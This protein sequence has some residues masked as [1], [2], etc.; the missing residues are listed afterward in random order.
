MYL[1]NMNWILLLTLVVSTLGLDP[2]LKGAVNNPTFLMFKDIAINDFNKKGSVINME[3]FVKD[4][5]IVTIEAKNITMKLKKIEPKSVY[6]NLTEGTSE[7]KF[8]GSNI[9]MNG[10]MKLIITF[11]GQKI[12]GDVAM[13]IKDLGFNSDLKFIK[14]GTKLAINVSKVGIN[15]QEKD[16]MI[17]I[18][19]SIGANILN[20]ITNFLKSYFFKSIKGACEQYFPDIISNITNT[21]ISSLPDDV[22]IMKGIAAKFIFIDP[23]K[24]KKNYAIIPILLYAHK[25]GVNKPPIAKPPQLPDLSDNCAKGIQ[26]F[27]SDYI[28]QSVVNVSHEGNLLKFEKNFKVL[29]L[30]MNVVCNTSSVPIINF[31]N[32]I[33]FRGNA[34]CILSTKILGSKIKIGLL[35]SIASLLNE[36]IRDSKIFLNINNLEILKITI[37]FGDYFDVKKIKRILNDIIKE[38]MPE[39]NKMLSTKG[40]PLPS[41]KNFDISDINQGIIGRY[42]AVCGNLKPKTSYFVFNYPRVFYYKP[43]F[44]SINYLE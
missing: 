43:K 33:D 4:L 34:T 21:I 37:I 31:K 32:G 24:I 42:I 3:D 10:T 25:E 6:M 30:K 23:P 38:F 13:S 19:G 20:I 39:L 27:I 40:I 16:I 9:F 15:L 36:T 5:T 18:T 14:N 41:I 12:N 44:N 22:S 35:L 7:I 26:L 11:L 8:G 29:G 2:S 1:I 28:I 17:T